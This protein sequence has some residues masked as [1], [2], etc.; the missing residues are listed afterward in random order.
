M[1]L[2]EAHCHSTTLTTRSSSERVAV[3]S[4][5]TRGCNTESETMPFSSKLVTVMMNSCALL[6]RPLESVAVTSTL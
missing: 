5:P 3:S 6:V 4:T 1:L 2:E